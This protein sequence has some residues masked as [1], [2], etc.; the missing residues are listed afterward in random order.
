MHYSYVSTYL[1]MVGKAYWEI[2]PVET[3]FLI[4]TFYS[5]SL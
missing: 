2:G 3:F 4:I 1:V 5:N